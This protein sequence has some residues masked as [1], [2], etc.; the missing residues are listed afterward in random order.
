MI[1]AIVLFS[2]V[3][4]SCSFSKY[5]TKW[6]LKG[7][8]PDE[9]EVR[10]EAATK[11]KT[12]KILY[13]GCGGVIIDNGSEAL[14]TDPFYS[15]QPF[16]NIQF[17]KI[18]VR[19]EHIEKGLRR[20]KEVNFDPKKIN[21]VLIAHSHYDHLM[22]VPYFL[23][24]NIFSDSLKIYGS[25]TTGNILSKFL[26]DTA[27]FVNLESKTFHPNNEF[28]KTGDWIS[29]SERI[30]VLPVEGEHAPHFLNIEMMHGEVG[31]EGIPG[32]KEATSKTKAT[33]WKRGKVYS[34]LID[35]MNSDK[36]E[37]RIFIQSSSCKPPFGIPPATELAEKKVDLAFIGVAS[38]Q[39]VKD[40]PATL[41]KTIDPAKTVLIH[42]ED[43]FRPYGSPVKTVRFTNFNKFFR[44]LSN[45]Y[46]VESLRDIKAKVIMPEP[47]TF[48]KAEY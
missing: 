37:Y 35:F 24:K 8:V 17:G 3:V 20:F 28:V 39:N 18:G 30:R 15:N 46:D 25:T 33:D 22:D 19:P 26:S 23:Q 40:Y 41:L 21:H 16:L 42:W 32:L 34:F 13:T 43:F 48:I 2:I 12:L 9:K 36:I 4:S 7:I 27:T 10:I 44:R 5:P 1:R 31:E 11:G 47:G 38:T 45:V 6:R 14:A 29:L